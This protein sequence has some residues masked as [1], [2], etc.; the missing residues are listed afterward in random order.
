[1]LCM[2]PDALVQ[3]VTVGN[4]KGLSRDSSNVPLPPVD[5]IKA[6][7][8]DD[9]N[10]VI[11]SKETLNLEEDEMEEMSKLSKKKN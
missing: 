6:K 2:N 5:V 3:P 11:F 8:K 7:A 4:K 10:P 9:I 1:M